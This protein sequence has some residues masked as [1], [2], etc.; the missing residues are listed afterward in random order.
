MNNAWNKIWPRRKR[1]RKRRLKTYVY[2]LMAG[3]VLA[4]LTLTSYQLDREQDYLD[5]HGVSVLAT[6]TQVSHSIRHRFSGNSIHVRFTDKT[7]LDHDAAVEV[8]YAR[9]EERNIGQTISIIYDPDKPKNAKLIN[10]TINHW[11]WLPYA[12]GFGA[13]LVMLDLRSFL[14]RRNSQQ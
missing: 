2:T 10:A 1:A 7:K 4:T 12:L 6:I 3:V 14:R 11:Y 5:N 13:I 8:G 9:Y